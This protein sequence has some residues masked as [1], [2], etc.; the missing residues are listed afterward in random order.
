M[1]W[2]PPGADSPGPEWRPPDGGTVEHTGP[3]PRAF[4][5]SS[6]TSAPQCVHWDSVFMDR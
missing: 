6:S 5:D 4:T 1:T 3:D 2:E